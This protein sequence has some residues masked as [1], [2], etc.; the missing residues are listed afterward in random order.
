MPGSTEFSLTIRFFLGESHRYPLSYFELGRSSF[1]IK[2]FLI[3]LL[4]LLY[5]LRSNLTG[6]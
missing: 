5:A 3:L 4:R 1:G 6:I 2:L